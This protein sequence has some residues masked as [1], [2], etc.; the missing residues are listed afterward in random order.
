MVERITFAYEDDEDGKSVLK[1]IVT[2]RD[3]ETG[4][5]S[6]V[7]LACPDSLKAAVEKLFA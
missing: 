1:M 5:V 6:H 4:E 2:K 3:K 7:G